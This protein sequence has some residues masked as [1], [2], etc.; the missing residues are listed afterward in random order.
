MVNACNMI[1]NA[2][3]PQIFP[4]YRGTMF[5]KSYQTERPVFLGVETI[6]THDLR[7]Q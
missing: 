3:I 6:F 4:D 2:E 7:Q 5:N 1:A